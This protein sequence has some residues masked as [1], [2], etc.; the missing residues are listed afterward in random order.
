MKRRARPNKFVAKTLKTKQTQPAC[1]SQMGGAQP[2]TAYV[3]LVPADE[4]HKVD[5]IIDIPGG[6]TGTIKELI[7]VANLN[8]F[9]DDE[10][11]KKVKPK[12]MSGKRQIV[13]G[14]VSNEV[15]AYING[16]IKY[17][18]PETHIAVKYN[19][20]IELYN[21]KNV[22]NN[23]STTGSE[24][25][26][27]VAKSAPESAAEPEPEP[28]HE[29]EEITEEQLNALRTE[30][31][32]NEPD[33]IKEEQKKMRYVLEAE[34][35]NILVKKNNTQI[36]SMP[37]PQV[38]KITLE[39]LTKVYSAFSK[40]SSHCVFFVYKYEIPDNSNKEVYIVFNKYTKPQIQQ[41]GKPAYLNSVDCNKQ[42]ENANSYIISPTVGE[43][44]D[45]KYKKEGI[46]NAEK[47]FNEKPIK[48]K[49]GKRITL[50][51]PKMAAKPAKKT[52]K[53]W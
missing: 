1:G 8:E 38:Q 53:R 34:K 22:S 23:P 25:A 4:T 21:Q 18:T 17:I 14:K 31:N 24:N 50:R 49:G 45:E 29:P 42:G 37:A 9:A 52:L 46:F 13:L 43:L 3:M 26:E 33:T 2:K 11:M 35:K 15:K 5:S 28:E 6:K 41:K 48:Q 16:E 44:D 20:N 39:N 32:K 51:R 12:A 10:S 47:Y 36:C 27:P 30:L 40:L 7:P 19:D